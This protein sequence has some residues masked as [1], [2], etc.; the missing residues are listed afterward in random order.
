MTLC[1]S[2]AT[3]DTAQDLLQQRKNSRQNKLFCMANLCRGFVASATEGQHD[4]RALDAR[5]NRSYSAPCEPAAAESL[6]FPTTNKGESTFATNLVCSACRNLKIANP[7]TVESRKRKRAEA[8]GQT[9]NERRKT[10]GPVVWRTA[11]GCALSWLLWLC[12]AGGWEGVL[13]LSAAALQRGAGTGAVQ[14]VKVGYMEQIRA[15]IKRFHLV[16]TASV[17]GSGPAEGGCKSTARI[18]IRIRC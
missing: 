16:P 3:C 15:E 1:V 2:C 13:Q 9:E 17:R 4:T 6:N 12:A 14:N 10:G 7:A 5:K 8:S 18:R 11:A